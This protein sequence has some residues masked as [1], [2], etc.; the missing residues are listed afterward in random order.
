MTT[1]IFVPPNIHDAPL[2]HYPTLISVLVRS[3]ARKA[4]EERMRSMGVRVSLTPLR[5]IVE[6]ARA[7]QQQHP[8]LVQQTIERVRNV[9]GFRTLAEQEARDRARKRKREMRGR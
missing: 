4:V 7:Y 5:I 8:E 6:E 3:S 1:P 9:A 2:I